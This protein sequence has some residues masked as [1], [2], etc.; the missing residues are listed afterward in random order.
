MGDM[1]SILNGSEE[2]ET[3]TETFETEQ[4]AEQPEQ[5]AAQETGVEASQVA[6][7]T[8]PAPEPE[9][10]KGLR[11]A[12]AAERKKRQELEQ[13]AEAYRLEL[14]TLR[15]QAKPE[16]EKP[17]LGEEYEQRFT[18]T[19]TRL[20]EEL[21]QT[22]IMMSRDFAMDK[23]ADYAEKEA[24]FIQMAKANP[25][26]IDQMRANANPA[27]F[28]YKTVSDFQQVQKLREIGDPV[29]YA[30]KLEQELREKIKAELLAEQ[31]A[32][33]KAATE[34]AI[35]AKLPKTGFAEERSSG[36]ARATP[37]K[38]N[39]PTPMGKILG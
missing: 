37:D 15:R 35:R 8:E 11:A 3:E 16:E 6:A 7:E 26:L 18:E 23:Y 1:D 20:K 5:E 27:A 24:E 25:V 21:V 39:G 36:T 31:E 13:A 32:G 14:E 33:K 12:A 9:E 4:V 28:A 19:E 29:A 30:T 38:F 17:F 22:K 10:V 34:A 2:T